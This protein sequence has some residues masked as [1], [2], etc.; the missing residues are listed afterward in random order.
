LPALRLYSGSSGFSF[1]EW[2]G[3]FYPA[4]LPQRR[5]LAHY[6]SHL[7]AVELNSTFYRMPKPELLAGWAGEVPAHF[8][9]AIKAPAHI[10]CRVKPAAAT[11]A[12]AQL[13][14][15]ARALGTGLGP[16]LFQLPPELPL[17]LDRLRELLAILPRGMRAAVELRH[18]SWRDPAVDAALRAAG[19]ARCITDMPERSE[20][21]V[22]ATAGFGYLRLRRARYGKAKLAAWCERIR[23][24]GWDECYVFFR[25]E[26]T[27]AAPRLARRLMAEFDS[28][29]A[30]PRA[31]ESGAT[32]WR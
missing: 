31:L 5:F 1:P 19:A 3:T 16:V 21:P 23:A 18:Q 7:D 15:A 4:D 30:P 29:D 12:M 26:D 27:A 2:K 13:W 14:A 10:S 11:G 9:F 22:V 28:A 20:P 24:A 25:H 8:R 32:A 6:A 17:D